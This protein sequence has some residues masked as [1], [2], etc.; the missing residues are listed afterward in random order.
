L[1]LKGEK[2]FS[3][4]KITEKSLAKFIKEVRKID[5]NLT[6]EECEQ[7]AKVYIFNNQKHSSLFYRISAIRSLSGKYKFKF[8]EIYLQTSFTIG[9]FF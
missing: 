3:N 1:I 9:C 7:L 4:G 6:I 8:N 2:L 5:N